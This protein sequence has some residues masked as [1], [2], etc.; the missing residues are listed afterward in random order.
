[1]TITEQLYKAL[2]DLYD[3]CLC[4]GNFKNGVTDATG[5]IDEGEV[6]A[7][8]YLDKARAAIAAYEA[9]KS[10]PVKLQRC[11][12]ANCDHVCAGDVRAIAAYEAKQVGG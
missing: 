9:S 2:S 7:G 1:M 5:T 8:D 11:Y 6:K 4:N 10:S 3:M 12:M